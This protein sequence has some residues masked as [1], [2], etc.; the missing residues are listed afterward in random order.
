MLNITSSY[1]ALLYKILS[2]RE[3]TTQLKKISPPPTKQPALHEGQHLKNLQQ[4]KQQDLDSIKV[5]YEVRHKTSSSNNPH[6]VKMSSENLQ[7]N[8]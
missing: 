3:C 1:T 7:Q 8:K 5:H 4:N 6:C 2:A